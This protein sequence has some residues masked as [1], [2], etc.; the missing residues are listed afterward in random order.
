MRN[1][2][3]SAERTGRVRGWP[4]KQSQ[5]C[6]TNPSWPGLGRAPM[7]KRCKTNPIWGGNAGASGTERAKRTQFPGWGWVGRYFR[8]ERRLC[9]TNPISATPGGGRGLRGAGREANVRNEPNFEQ[10][11][12]DRRPNCAKQSQI[13][14]G[15]DIWGAAHQGGGRLCKTNP[16]PGGTGWDNVPGAWDAGKCAKR[17]QFGAARLASDGKSCK[18]K[19]ICPEASFRR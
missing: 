11:D 3:N 2:A 17:T 19:P 15:W 18:T 6:K 7:G 12:R 10:P 16:I 1:E 4:C 9:E 8:D 14:A 13:W 5:S